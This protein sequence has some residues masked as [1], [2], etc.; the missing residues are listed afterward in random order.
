LVIV[1]SDLAVQAIEALIHVNL[2]TLLD[3]ADWADSL[4]VTTAAAT[5]RVAVQPIEHANAP[6]DGKPGSKRACEAAIETFH[7]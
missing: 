4:A 1:V 2:A 3:S 5:F 6:H 7:E